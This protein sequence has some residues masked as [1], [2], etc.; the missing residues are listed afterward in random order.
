MFSKTVQLF[1]SAAHVV[2]YF[3]NETNAHSEYLSMH[4]DHF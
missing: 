1:G 4:P 3:V 2:I